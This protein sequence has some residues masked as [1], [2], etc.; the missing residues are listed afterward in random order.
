MDA[1]AKHRRDRP[2][3]A[4]EPS[5]TLARLLARVP[6][7]VRASFTEAQLVALDGALDLNNPSGHPINIRV[8]LF[9]WAYLVVLGGREARKPKRRA[10]EREKHPLSSPGNI[11]FLIGVGILGLCLGNGLRWIVL[12]G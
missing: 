11:A 12:G 6:P 3:S 1:P 5:A 8:T 4:Y 9:D 10:E 2:D 7:A